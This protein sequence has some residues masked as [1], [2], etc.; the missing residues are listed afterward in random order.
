[1]FDQLNR[2]RGKGRLGRKAGLG[3]DAGQVL[4]F[5]VGFNRRVEVAE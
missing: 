4:G 2:H 5:G 1:M 3:V